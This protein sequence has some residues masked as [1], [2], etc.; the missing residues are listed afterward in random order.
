MLVEVSEV[1]LVEREEVM[2]PEEKIEVD[3]MERG[4]VLHFTQKDKE[5]E[6]VTVKNLL[7]EREN[8]MATESRMVIE[9][10]KDRIVEMKVEVEED[11]PSK[12]KRKE[13][14]RAIWYSFS[15]FSK[16]LPTSTSPNSK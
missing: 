9:E 8:L 15:F 12:S 6:E 2:V 3:L 7:T 16:S 5:K 11:N 14:I 1:D 13:S 10:R 4:E